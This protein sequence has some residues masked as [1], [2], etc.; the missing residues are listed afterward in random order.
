[1]FPPK[2]RSS[3]KAVLKFQLRLCL[4]LEKGW[5]RAFSNPLKAL[6][7]KKKRCFLQCSHQNALQ[8]EVV[9]CI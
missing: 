7:L 5:K 2:V 1:M 3:N 4:R 8:V 9:C 6:E